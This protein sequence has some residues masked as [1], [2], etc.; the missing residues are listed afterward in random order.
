MAAQDLVQRLE[1]ELTGASA[2]RIGERALDEHGSE[3]AIAFSGSED[4][5]LVEYAKQSGRPFRVF[6]LD[7][8]RLHAE[9]YRF[10]EKVEQHYEIRIEYCFPAAPMVEAMVRK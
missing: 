6:T 10:F 8:G 5:L 1:R 4:V 2:A 7:T 3:V 9:T